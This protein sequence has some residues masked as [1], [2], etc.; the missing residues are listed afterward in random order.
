MAVTKRFANNISGKYRDWA[1]GSYDDWIRLGSDQKVL[2][3]IAK[4]LDM[5]FEV[6]DAFMTTVDPGW[7]SYDV[8]PVE[9][10]KERA[11]CVIDF[12]KMREKAILKKRGERK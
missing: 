1:K 8:V 9:E 10:I 5:P 7:E 6:V 4:E 11:Q 2:L 3:R 12:I